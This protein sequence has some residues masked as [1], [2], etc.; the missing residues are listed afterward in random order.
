MYSWIYVHVITCIT[1]VQHLLNIEILVVNGAGLDNLLRAKSNH[2]QELILVGALM[3]VCKQFLTMSF[4]R[5]RTHKVLYK[6][7][8]VSALMH[9][10]YNAHTIIQFWLLRIGADILVLCNLRLAFEKARLSSGLAAQPWRQGTA[11][12]TLAP[13]PS[14]LSNFR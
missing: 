4:Y 7:S 11:S 1:Y 6:F 2:F 5:K 10:R 8:T 13:E 3:F 9:W 12:S 14:L